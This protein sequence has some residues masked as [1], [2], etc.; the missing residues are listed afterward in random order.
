MEIEILPQI[1]QIHYQIKIGFKDAK[2]LSF[3][4][5]DIKKQKHEK[6][7]REILN[8]I[9]GISKV[10]YYTGQNIYL[11]VSWTNMPKHKELLERVVNIIQEY[12][13]DTEEK[14]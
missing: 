6:N 1:V 5:T 10:N 12:V 8:S 3:W 4:D 9:Q 11:S 13:A 14:G 7:L 2:L